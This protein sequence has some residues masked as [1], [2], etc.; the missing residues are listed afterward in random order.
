MANSFS[1]NKEAQTL[2]ALACLHE[3]GDNGLAITEADLAEPKAARILETLPL[4]TTFTSATPAEKA[5][6]L[7]GHYQELQIES[8]I[9]HDKPPVISQIAA[10]ES[11]DKMLRAALEKRFP[12]TQGK[13]ELPFD[14]HEPCWREMIQGDTLHINDKVYTELL[15]SYDGKTEQGY[16]LLAN[17][18]TKV[19]EK[20][21]RPKHFEAPTTFHFDTGW[22][23]YVASYL[24][25]TGSPYVIVGT[26]HS[27]PEP[28][29]P[30]PQNVHF[31]A[32]LP[33]SPMDGK[34]LP[35]ANFQLIGHNKQVKAYDIQ[36][37]KKFYPLQNVLSNTSPIL[38]DL[39]TDNFEPDKRGEI[40]MR[41]TPEEVKSMINAAPKGNKIRQHAAGKKEPKLKVTYFYDGSYEVTL[42]FAEEPTPFFHLIHQ[43][44]TTG[45]GDWADERGYSGQLTAMWDEESTPIQL[46]EPNEISDAIQSIQKIL[47]NR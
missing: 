27:H 33:S 18:K 23:E 2:Y 13:K 37:A 40:E 30:L 1:I 8:K 16:L 22:V 26:Y 31:A 15:S 6:Y 34:F 7:T 45:R 4:N 12:Q 24:K 35:L 29:Q 39:S 5:K 44:H 41:L 25:K 17:R 3:D 36:G 42:H 38:T 14:P 28:P 32:E 20:V 11:S 10:L 9:F 46:F 21:I 47:V 19:I 43:M